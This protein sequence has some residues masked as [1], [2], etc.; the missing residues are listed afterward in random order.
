VIV[1]AALERLQ[2]RERLRACFAHRQSHAIYAPH[3]IWLLLV[4]HLLLGFRRLRDRDYY[5]EDPLIGRVLGLQRLPDVA[6]ISRSLREGDTRSVEDTRRL[7]RT[8]VRERLELERLS[9]ELDFDGSVQST[10]GHAEGTAIGYNPRRKGQRSYYPLF[11]TVAPTQQFLDVLHRPGNVHDSNGALEFMQECVG[12]VRGTVLGARIEARVDSAFF[13][14]RIVGALDDACVAFTASVPFSRLTQLKHCIE[15]RRR[16]HTIDP[17]W[18]YFERRWKPKSWGRR[19]R[20]IFV[21]QFVAERVHGP[22][23]L[24]LF[25][26]VD[27]Q[28]KYTPSLQTRSMRSLGSQ[29]NGRRFHLKNAELPE[30]SRQSARGGIPGMQHQG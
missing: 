20:F 14:E 26:P 13:D 4:V 19:Y 9:L 7:L 11:C 30:N 10:K 8:V 28:A 5:R 15:Q 3:T 12:H 24:S 21:R 17:Q 29:G 23:Q 25:E 22:L 1:Q 6:T 27:S 2:L 18:S 16:W